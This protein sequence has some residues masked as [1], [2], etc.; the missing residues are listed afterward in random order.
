MH[1][2][3]FVFSVQGILSNFSFHKMLLNSFSMAVI[4]IVFHRMGEG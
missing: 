2:V 1:Y 4:S 3:Y